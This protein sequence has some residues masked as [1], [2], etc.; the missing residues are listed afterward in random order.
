[1]SL[2][3]VF[4]RPVPIATL[5]ELEDFL[6]S[7]AAFLVQKCIYEYARARC[8]LHWQKL[9]KEEAFIQALETS[10]WS[11]YPL[12]LGSVAEMVFGS[13][14]ARATGGQSVPAQSIAAAVRAVTRRYPPRGVFGE[15]FWADAAKAIELRLDHAA[16]AAPKPVKD[17]PLP[18]QKLFFDQLPLHDSLRGHDFVLVGNNVRMNLCRMYEEFESRMRPEPL[19]AALGGG[20]L[21][22]AS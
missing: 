1:M 16:L 19:I 22:G 17:I 3:N 20:A 13:L 10:R 18:Y 8:G 4:R 14:H 21:A 7:R 15:A 2:M 9:F 6:D 5:A 12:A 11:N